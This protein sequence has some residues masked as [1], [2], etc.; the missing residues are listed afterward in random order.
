M[1]VPF[2]DIGK[3]NSTIATKI[4]EAANRA[5]DSGWYILGKECS[6]FEQAMATQLVG[7]SVI[8]CN[9]GTDALLLSLLAAGIGRGDEVITVANTAIPTVAAICSTGATPVFVDVTCDTW[10]LDNK[11]A[12]AAL[13]SRTRAIIAVHLYGNV[14]DINELKRALQDAGRDEVVIV[15]DVAQAQGAMLN[16]NSAGTIG[17]FGAFSFYP[18]KNIGALGDGGA[19]HCS[20][21]SDSVAI[22]ALRNYGQKDRYHAETARGVNSRLDE[23]Q[24]AIL[25]VKLP[26]LASWN[27][28]K[29]SLMNCYRRELAG[30]PIAFQTATSGCNPA[31]HLC[32]ISVENEL[33]RDHLQDHLTRDGIQTLIHYPI[34]CHQQTAF[35]SS[36]RP[37]L[38]ITEG[39]AK[40][41]LSLPLSPVLSDLEQ[42]HVISSIQKYYNL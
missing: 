11:L 2:F 9:S 18:S 38:P 21:E 42:E 16:G 27:Q 20:N 12:I 34:P 40:K 35:A 4:H 31:W 36:I 41:I 3:L 32:V 26:F 6:V 28:R 22:K 15:E 17:R 1:H 8:G 5:L 25:S 14:A 24:A 39:L 33:I 23:V 13:T 19:V 37:E 7:E 29:K 30:L 10:L